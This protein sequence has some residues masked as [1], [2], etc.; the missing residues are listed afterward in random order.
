MTNVLKKYN[1]NK[2]N[3]KNVKISFQH[4]IVNNSRKLMINN[5]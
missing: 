2:L 1:K 3:N 4:S 5:N